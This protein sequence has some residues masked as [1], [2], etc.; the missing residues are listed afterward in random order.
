MAAA[1]AVVP[2]SLLN[3]T[4][5]N[6]EIMGVETIHVNIRHLKIMD[7]FT[8]FIHARHTCDGCPKAPIIG[9]CRGTTRD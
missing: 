3:Y 7:T 9:F 8:T 2:P 4:L 6:D 1:V 5:S